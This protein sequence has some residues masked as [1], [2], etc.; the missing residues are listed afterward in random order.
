MHTTTACLAWCIQN[1]VAV[2][3]TGKHK[4][5]VGAA[6]LKLTLLMNIQVVSVNAMVVMIAMLSKDT[7]V[8][9]WLCKS[10]AAG[11]QCTRGHEA[12]IEAFIQRPAIQACIQK[13]CLH[14]TE[15]VFVVENMQLLGNTSGVAP[16]Q[17]MVATSAA[18]YKL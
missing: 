5:C 1:V 17:A 16:L 8:W 12:A 6:R 15:T 11:C 4:T 9:H 13:Q 3:T 18:S 10:V 7:S 2:Y 14:T